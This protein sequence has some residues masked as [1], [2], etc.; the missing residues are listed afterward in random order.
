VNST[1]SITISAN[2][3]G[4]TTTGTATIGATTGGTDYLFFSVDRLNSSTAS[5]GTS[6]G[7]GCILSYTINTPTSTPTLS[8]SAQVNTVETP[9]CWSTSAIIVDNSVPSG[10]LAGASQIYLLEL[11]AN[12]A[13]GPTRGTYTSS[14]C[15]TGDTAA[16]IALQGAQSG[17]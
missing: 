4:S 8:G 5:C 3:T 6:N 9:G 7:D 16:P 10:T 17:P 15:G 2:G 1:T 13:G 11:N 14:T 12:G